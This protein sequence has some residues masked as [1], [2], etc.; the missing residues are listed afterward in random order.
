M[1][2]SLV[3][4]GSFYAAG[5]LLD[6]PFMRSLHDDARASVLAVATPVRGMPPAKRPGFLRRR[7]GRR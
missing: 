7:F 4:G 5:K 2:C 1:F 3:V 6:V